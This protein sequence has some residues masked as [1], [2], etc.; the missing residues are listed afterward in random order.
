MGPQNPL[1]DFRV[2]QAT[3]G[4]LIFAIFAPIID[5][6]FYEPGT[7]LRCV[8]GERTSSS[9]LMHLRIRQLNATLTEGDAKRIDGNIL[10]DFGDELLFQE[11]KPNKH[12]WS[13]DFLK[14]MLMMMNGLGSRAVGIV[15]ADNEDLYSFGI[16][17][18]R[19]EFKIM[20]MA[21]TFK[22]A[23][24]VSVLE[25]LTVPDNVTSIEGLDE[26]LK[27]AFSMII[28][29]GLIKQQD[30]LQH[31]FQATDDQ[32]EL[33]IRNY[34]DVLFSE[35]PARA[36]RNSTEASCND[37]E[38][39]QTEESSA[40]VPRRTNKLER[41]LDLAVS[42]PLKNIGGRAHVT[43]SRLL[44]T[45]QQ[46]VVKWAGDDADSRALFA[47]EVNLLSIAHSAKV[48]HIIPIMG[49][50]SIH[51]RFGKHGLVMPRYQEVSRKLMCSFTEEDVI[52]LAL[53][54]SAALEGLHAL[55]I[56]HCDVKP[57]NIVMDEKGDFYLIDFGQA[58]VDSLAFVD[59][60]AR[61][62]EYFVAPEVERGQ[63]GG[64]AADVFS[65][66]AT[67]SRAFCLQ[68]KGAFR[69]SK[70]HTLSL[71]MMSSYPA[72][73]PSPSHVLHSLR[74]LLST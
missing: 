50:V 42:R 4:S 29:K 61:G 21:P 72:K 1:T 39:E 6:P 74:T 22:T 37:G 2:N 23:L 57:D 34:G 25:N 47:N 30:D 33:N 19:N 73:R 7:R 56:V 64:P 62:T 49:C 68:R 26:A 32:I 55:R 5:W 3:E 11:F 40:S 43:F 65:L 9:H 59:G 31:D 13:D 12:K 20:M 14:L 70:L 16:Q 17:G 53:Q 36:N 60:R 15:G 27:I 18:L 46:A 8:R 51:T 48:P 35:L 24:T 41:D 52:R 54:M 28:L 71:K 67:I 44:S 45:G 10:N 69:E 63:W 66:G 58:Q 38:S